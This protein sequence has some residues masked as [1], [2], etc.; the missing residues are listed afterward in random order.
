[1][2]LWLLVGGFACHP[3]QGDG[4]RSLLHR[5][6]GGRWRH[7]AAVAIGVVCWIAPISNRG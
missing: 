3:Q 4:G 1:V 5:R 7:E 6:C 2:S